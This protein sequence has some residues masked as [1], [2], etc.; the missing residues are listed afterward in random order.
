[1]IHVFLAK[2]KK[3]NQRLLDYLQKHQIVF[4]SY[5]YELIDEEVLTYFMQCTEDCFEF[6]SVEM[7]K[8]KEAEELSMRDFSRMVLADVGRNFKL[9]LVIYNDRIYPKV[10]EE[11]AETFLSRREKEYLRKTYL[12][13]ALAL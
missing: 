7:L 1:M 11:L 3:A 9:P 10:D 2:N 13:R 8:Y 6:L 12:T 4:E 5:P